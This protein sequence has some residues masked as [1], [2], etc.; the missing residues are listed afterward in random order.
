MDL[1]DTV[2]EFELLPKY[3]NIVAFPSRFYEYLKSLYGCSGTERIQ[4]DPADG[5][6]ARVAVSI[7]G[8]PA[9]EMDLAWTIHLQKSRHVDNLSRDARILVL[10]QWKG[11]SLLA[12]T[13]CIEVQS[14]GGRQLKNEGETYAECKLFLLHPPMLAPKNHSI[15][16]LRVISVFTQVLQEFLSKEME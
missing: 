9:I 2:T 16:A 4:K 5:I 12:Y 7:P 15:D 3:Q 10:S 8:F 11:D 13:R 14:M 6:L 1:P